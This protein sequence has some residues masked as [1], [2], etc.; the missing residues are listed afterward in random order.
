MIS[1]SV[2]YGE[3]N[4]PIDEPTHIFCDNEAIVMNSTM[5]ESTL[6]KKPVVI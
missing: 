4:I 5:P 1:L 6:K 3:F 2:D